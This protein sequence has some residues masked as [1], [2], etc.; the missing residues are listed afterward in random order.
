M[1]LIVLLG[2]AAPLASLRL[3]AVRTA[4]LAVALASIYVA[5]AVLAF[6]SGWIVSVVYPLAA[7]R[8]TSFGTLSSTT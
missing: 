5:A 1:L 8:V 7:L 2:M 3:S 6:N 4:L